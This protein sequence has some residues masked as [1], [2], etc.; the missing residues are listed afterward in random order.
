MDVIGSNSRQWAQHRSAESSHF[1]P[2]ATFLMAADPTPMQR[3]QR[4]GCTSIK[5]RRDSEGEPKD[6]KGAMY[7]KECMILWFENEN[8]PFETT[9]HLIIFCGGKLHVIQL[10]QLTKILVLPLG[11]M[12]WSSK[13]QCLTVPQV[14][15][16]QCARGYVSSN[17]PTS[18]PR[19]SV[20]RL[21][22]MEGDGNH[23]VV[24]DE[25][26]VEINY[27]MAGQNIIGD[28]GPS[29]RTMVS[30]TGGKVKVVK[31]ADDLL[32]EVLDGRSGDNEVDEWDRLNEEQ[33]E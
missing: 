24:A 22:K 31:P 8:E 11:V 10:R 19:G 3:C 7:C 14:E 20:L 13:E 1:N 9:W 2:I 15:P 18:N 33:I 4:K 6:Y 27:T 25:D 12:A 26:L 30:C 16:G 23:C 29:R 5:M 28:F 32:K 21:L 17:A